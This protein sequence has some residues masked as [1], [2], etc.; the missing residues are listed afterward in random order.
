MFEKL[1]KYLLPREVVASFEL[2]SIKEETSIFHLHLDE[3]D[4]KSSKYHGIEIFSNGFYAA[5]TIKDFPLRNKKVVLHIRCRRWVDK[6]GK[7]YS[8]DWRLT[9]SGTRY[10]EEF[11]SFLKAVFGYLPDNC[12]IP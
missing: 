2:V 9:A 1:V 11:A 7:S 10:S 6:N 4:K 8:N 3:K 5:S 12:P